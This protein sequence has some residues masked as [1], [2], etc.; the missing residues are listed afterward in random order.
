M[1]I[2]KVG[3]K[4]KIFDGRYLKVWETEFYDK[5]GKKQ[6]WEWLEKK[7]VVFIFPIT[8][9]R[10]IILIKNFRI[11]LERYVIEMP[12]GLKD[13]IGESDIDLA[14]RELLEETGYSAKTLIPVNPWPYRS[15]SS[16]VILQGF[17]ALDL[18][19]VKEEVGDETED[20]SVVEVGVD[21]LFN[22]YFNLPENVFF[23]IGILA[24]YGIANN[25]G[26]INK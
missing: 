2:I 21:E 17:I 3:I 15:G 25:L 13:R 16:D 11:P 14:T 23:D 4:R 1:G 10:K 9:D 5:T 18:L 26:L 7:G 22:F 20:I 12:A 24:M 19:K 6:I 8:N